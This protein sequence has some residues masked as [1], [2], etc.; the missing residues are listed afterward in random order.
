MSDLPLFYRGIYRGVPVTRITN[1]A[2]IALSTAFPSN[3]AAFA[4]RLRT[5]LEGR[6]FKITMEIH[7]PPVNTT[8][9]YGVYSDDGTGTKPVNLLTTCQ[10]VLV[11][12]TFSGQAAFIPSPQIKIAGNTYFWPGFVSDFDS[13]FTDLRTQAP[14]PTTVG[15]TSM[16]TINVLPNPWTDGGSTIGAFITASFKSTIGPI[17]DYLLDELESR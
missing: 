14:V 9:K 3:T 17:G 1:T 7:N 12:T 10:P 16:A 15:R 8:F 2:G 13:S 5:K 4:S 6:L 11:P